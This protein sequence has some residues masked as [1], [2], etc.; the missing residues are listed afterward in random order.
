M[1]GITLD[2]IVL[3]AATSNIAISDGTDTLAI[4]GDGSLNATVTASD[5]DIRD[6]T[7][8]SDSVKIG[9]GTEFLEVNAD[10]SINVSF[11]VPV[12]DDDAD[13]GNPLKIGGRGLSGALS[14]LSASGDRFDM[15]GDLYRRMYTSDRFNVGHKVTRETVGATAAQIVA[16]PF[17]GRKA[18]TIQNVSS[19]SLWLGTDNTVTADDTATGGIEIPK[20]ASYTDDFGEDID[21]WLIS[22]GAGKTAKV[23]EK[24]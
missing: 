14:A 6:L 9:D 11:S 8:V 4:N 17:A 16:T 23:H 1:A 15:I 22:D 19:S 7:H 13:S 18:V 10:G 24:G 2:E 12:A 5:L 3:D 21:I 20:N